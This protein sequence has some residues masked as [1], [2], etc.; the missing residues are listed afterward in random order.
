MYIT[1][2]L[3]YKPHQD[4]KIYKKNELE[5]AVIEIMNLK[6]AN[7]LLVAYI[8]ILQWILLI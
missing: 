1:N 8:N 6:K 3:S 4:L 7:L 2:H 5:S